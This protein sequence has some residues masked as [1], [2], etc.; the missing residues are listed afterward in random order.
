MPLN[1]DEVRRL[2]EV[3]A[4]WWDVPTLQQ[5][6]NDNFSIDLANKVPAG[7]LFERA[8]KLI[9]DMNVPPNDRILLDAFEMY[10]NAAIRAIAQDL[11]KPK[12]FS[13]TGHPHDAIILGRAAFV[14]RDG[15]RQAL[16]PFTGAQTRVLIVRGPDACGKSYTWELLRLLAREQLGAIAQRLRI[17]DPRITPREFVAQ[18]FSLL[19]LDVNKL[20]PLPD[21]PQLAH[22]D[23]L[24]NAFKGQMVKLPKRYWLVID[25]LNDPQVTRDVRET[26][27]AL[28]YAVEET[29]PENLWVALLGYNSE[30]ADTDLRWVAQEDARF[31]DATHLGT[32]FESLAA[33]GPKPLTAERAREIAKVIMTSLAVPTKDAM[34]KLTQD[35]EAIG[36]KLKAGLQP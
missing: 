22:V 27:Y 34:A 21:Q 17:K 20:P 33:A 23:P 32:H 2:T 18:A 28:A 31:F 9:S 19:D 14:D 16:P 7:G 29:Q 10:G 11:L 5:F 15:L 26:A 12:Y 4:Q 25:D 24:V 35:V 30:V 36:E 8:F 6:A 3:I 13:P 1:G